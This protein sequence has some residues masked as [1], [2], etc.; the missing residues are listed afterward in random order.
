ME[1]WDK[2]VAQPC[3]VALGPASKILQQFFVFVDGCLLPIDATSSLE[4][5]DRLF[6]AHFVFGTEYDHN[7]LGLWKFV[8]VF[9]YELDVESTKIPR[10][11]K[12]VFT[13][14][15]ATNLGY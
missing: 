2:A 11:A 15:R 7:L 5:I 14:L 4:A 13:Q 12:E 9:I 3:M 6:K 10:K 1:S 8:Q